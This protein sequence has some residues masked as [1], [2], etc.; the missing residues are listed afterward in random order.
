ML[1]ILVCAAS[2]S[3]SIAAM[4]DFDFPGWRSMV[5]CTF[6]VLIP[7]LGLEA[8]L[9]PKLFWIGPVVALIAGGFLI[10][11]VCGMSVKR[12]C[13]A[14]AI[15]LACR[16]LLFWAFPLANPRLQQKLR[17]G[18]TTNS[19]KIVLSTSKLQRLS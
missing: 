3:F 19:T 10:S 14:V 15:M 12:G 6:A 2:L 4:D 18:M 17:N 9:P 16:F 5:A 7:L 1:E 13:L 8:M 11:A